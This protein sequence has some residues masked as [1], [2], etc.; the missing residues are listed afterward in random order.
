MHKYNNT[1]NCFSCHHAETS[2]KVPIQ[3]V[4]VVARQTEE[5][6]KTLLLR[7]IAIK[8]NISHKDLQQE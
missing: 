6:M 7:K 8:S 2:Y 3:H 4:T 5:C 1:L